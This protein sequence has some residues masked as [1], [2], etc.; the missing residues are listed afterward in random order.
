MRDMLEQYLERIIAITV[1]AELGISLDPPE[2]I[3][4][5]E[6][7]RMRM[8]RT[9][10]AY[11][12]FINRELFQPL[13]ASSDSADVACGRELRDECTALADA[14]RAHTRKWS[15]VRPAEMW[16]EYRPAALAM[17]QRIRAHTLRVRAGAERLDQEAAASP[18][19]PTDA[20]PPTSEAYLRQMVRTSL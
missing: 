12:L 2:D 17:I 19:L 5:L 8:A 16:D 3:A 7:Q 11:Q 1:A 15:G 18:E 20:M 13:L 10:T 4:R 6:Y 9:L 14:M